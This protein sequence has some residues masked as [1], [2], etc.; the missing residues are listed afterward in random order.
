MERSLI[1]GDGEVWEKLGNKAIVLQKLERAI[2]RREGIRGDGSYGKDGK[3]G[4]YGTNALRLVDGWGDG[5]EGVE[6]DDFAG[7]WLVQTREGRFPEWLR[8]VTRMKGA[9]AIYW[10][11]L[12]GGKEAPVWIEGEVA[13]EPFEVMENGVRFWIDF[14][15]GYSQGI[16]L[17]QRDN[18]AEMRKRGRGL[19]VL[20]CFAYTCGFGVAAGLGGAETVNI[21]LSKRYLEWGRRNYESNGIEAGGH[22][23]IY[24]EVLNWL[25][26]FA[27]KGRRFDLVILDPPTFSR[28]KE[29]RIFT[30]EAGF[31]KLVRAAEGVLGETGGLFCSTNQRGLTGEGFRR[32]IGQGLA[33][34]EGWRMEERGMP[35]DFTGER[36]L[37]CVWVERR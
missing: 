15:A 4:K 7:R 27:R 25:E 34:P 16:F 23:F 33:R 10:K 26:R 5:I 32:L 22:E 37:K 29:G 30:V 13:R 1:D 14:T 35:G 18:R 17:D 28:D 9:R 19:R 8:G 12:G 31:A 3:D 11:V 20:N 2:A 24:G 36:Y 6:I 21:D